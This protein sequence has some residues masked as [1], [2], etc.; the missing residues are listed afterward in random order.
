[1]RSAFFHHIESD[2]LASRFACFKPWLAAAAIYNLTWG[3]TTLT[4]PNAFFN[5]TGMPLPNYPTL[6]Q[7]IG[8]FVLVFAPGYAWAARDPF[9][10]RHLILIGFV[11]KL[12]GLTGYAWFAARGALPPIFGCAIL[13][14]DLIWLPA[15]AIFLRKAAALCGGWRELAKGS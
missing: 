7:C 6:W 14:N 1:M 13:T 10:F 4:F 5:A 3:L 15:F 11:G 8:M 12:C 9:R 2:D